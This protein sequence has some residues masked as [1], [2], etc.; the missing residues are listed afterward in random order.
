MQ[1]SLLRWTSTSVGTPSW[2]RNRWSI[3]QRPVPSGNA[4]LAPDQQPS[5]G[6]L[7]VDLAAGQEIRVARQEMLE[8]VL[9]V[10]A[11]AGEFGEPAVLKQKDAVAHALLTEQG[12]SR[13]G[14]L[15]ACFEGGA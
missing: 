10:E 14:S 8:D 4:H 1:V 15:G 13:H 5:P 6:R 12:R 3:D 11:L 9:G 2:S 7:A